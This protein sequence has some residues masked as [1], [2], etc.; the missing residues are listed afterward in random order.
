LLPSSGGKQ[1]QQEIN[2][3]TSVRE[4]SSFRSNRELRDLL[5]SV[6]KIVGKFE[7]GDYFHSAWISKFKRDVI[8]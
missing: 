8:Y 6:S 1:A 4:S 2:V 5:R 7:E 3:E